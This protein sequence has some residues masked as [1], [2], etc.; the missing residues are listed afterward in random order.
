MKKKLLSL[1]CVVAL[2]AASLVFPTCVF[3]DDVSVAATSLPA[4]P[5][6]EGGGMWTTGARA[7][8]S[9]TIVHVTNLNDKGTGSLREAVS[10]DNRVIVFDVA[11]TIKLE[12]SLSISKNNLTILGQTAPGDGICIRGANTYVTGD[13]IIIRYL[14]FRMG[15]TNETQELNS[16]AD[17]L[18]YIKDHAV[19]EDAFGANDSTN[20][21]I[22][23][24]SMSWSTDEC[25]SV[26]AVKNAT[27]QWCLIGEGL[28]RSVHVENGDD[29]QEHS[30]GGIVGGQNLSYHHNLIAN[31][32][33]RFPRVGTSA[34]VSSYNGQA[35]KYG[36]VDIRNNV[37]YNWGV[38]NAYGGENGMRVNLVN[39]YYKEGAN[40]SQKNIF[41]EMSTPDSKK[42]KPG[43]VAGWGTDI[44]ISGNYYEPLKA[45]DKIDKINEDNKAGVSRKDATDYK[46]VDYTDSDASHGEYIKDYPITTNN[47][48]D[49]YTLVI[50]RAGASLVRDSVDIRLANDAKNGTTTAGNKGLINFPGNLLNPSKN[51]SDPAAWPVLTGTKKTDSDNDGIPDDW[52]E[53]HGLNKNSAADAL[54]KNSD[55]YLN[56]EVYANDL[57][58]LPDPDTTDK[59]ALNAAIERAEQVAEGSV[60]PES[61]A[62][63]TEAL[64]KAKDI[65]I[66]ISVT[67]EQVD[68]ATSALEDVLDRLVPNDKYELGVKIKEGESYSEGYTPLSL[69]RLSDALTKGREVYSAANPPLSDIN[70]AVD[71]IDKAIENLLNIPVVESEGEIV[72]LDFNDGT[73]GAAIPTK[74]DADAKFYNVGNKDTELTYKQREG[75]DLAVYLKDNSDSL[76]A[77]MAVPFATQERGK[78]EISADLKLEDKGTKMDIFSLLDDSDRYVLSVGTPEKGKDDWSLHEFNDEGT[79]SKFVDITRSSE[80]KLQLDKWYTIKIT[81]DLDKK[82]VSVSSNGFEGLTDYA[83]ERVISNISS[84]TFKGSLSSTSRHIWVDNVVASVTAHIPD[85]SLDTTQLQAAIESAK[86]LL[87]GGDDA[88]LRAALSDAE[89]V[90]DADEKYQTDVDWAL[91]NLNEALASYGITPSPSPSASTEPSPSPSASTE[92][93]P[94]PSATT[95]PSPS[96]SA[97]TEPSPSPSAST[98]PSPSP[99]ASTDP[100]KRFLL[101]AEIV[102]S[103]VNAKIENTTDQTY[104]DAFFAIVSYDASGKMLD[105]KPQIIDITKDYIKEFKESVIEGVKTKIFVWSKELT[106]LL[107]KEFF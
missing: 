10:K 16:A 7:S 25:C 11:G 14:R 45:S 70:A 76:A 40:T 85:T 33:G 22:D 84:V 28:N 69:K 42:L 1:V 98:E 31:C 92:P 18:A 23:H 63:L 4:F 20:L 5:G 97:S 101:T 58:E 95:E 87:S 90:M 88:N 9:A 43:S 32:K 59:T 38:S 67:Q 56:I 82:T 71:A 65:S 8:S 66:S 27:V 72:H 73:A 62:E 34:T 93:S 91:E 39:N 44:A 105:C 99:S 24:C 81:L 107:I 51:N 13:N 78:I 35:D 15:T 89:A 102:D 106:P 19:Y 36:L 29:W 79:V 49:A 61:W 103:V 83:Y 60:M 86:E 21:I 3:S 57:V 104:D 2:I 94:S 46:I 80:G 64:K 68:E 74:D 47:A 96:P 50:E 37:M 55:G 54:T 12:S 41:Y 75:D 30:Y 52:E 6:A 53:E 17:V 77:I 48:Q 26:Y 100:E